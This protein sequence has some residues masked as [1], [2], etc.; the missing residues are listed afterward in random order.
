MKKGMLIDQADNVGVVLE[1]VSEGDTVQCG[2]VCITATEPIAVPHK[3]ALKAMKVGDAIIKYGEC[4]GYATQDISTGAHVHV[5]N[6]DS[7]KLM[8]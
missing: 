2:A 4:V 8:K 6:M 5:H 1:N 7:E 3:I